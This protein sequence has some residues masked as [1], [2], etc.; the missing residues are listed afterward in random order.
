MKRKFDGEATSKDNEGTTGGTGGPDRMR[1]QEQIDREVQ[2]TLLCLDR[3][4]PP[5][6]RPDFYARVQARIRVAEHPGR[7]T[8]ALLFLRRV[9]VPAGLTVMLGLNIL[10]AVLVMRQPDSDAAGRQ[11]AMAALA[12]EVG[13]ESSAVS[14]YWK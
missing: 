9:L 4:A 6:P 11:K 13:L 5:R 14:S 3:M 8:A 12:E 10:T 1:I 7:P 2:K